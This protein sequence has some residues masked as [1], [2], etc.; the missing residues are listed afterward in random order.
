[1]AVEPVRKRRFSVN[2]LLDGFFFVFAGVASVW[3]AWLVLTESFAFGWWGIALFVVFWLA[4]RLPR[5]PTAA[6][7]P[8]DDLRARLLH[9][10]CAHERRAARRS[11]EPCARRRRGIRAR[12]DARRRMDARRRR[13][14][15]FELAHRDLDD[16]QTQL[17]RGA[18]QP[19][20]PLRTRAGLRLSAGGRGKPGETPPRALL[21]HARGMAPAR[22]PPC[23]LA[24]RRHLRP[25]GRVLAV[26]AAGHAQDRRR[27]RCR[28]RPHRRDRARRQPSGTRRRARRLLDR[29]PLPQ[30]RRRHHPHR[31]RPAGARPAVR[32]R[33]ERVEAAT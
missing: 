30:R 18:G 25:R 23:G 32:C 15:R 28:A 12:R 31:R 24:R 5:A 6:S 27:H 9:R 13:D 1:M 16:H 29:V 26:H 3:L 2:A 10:S 21:A 19:A 11:R 8:D 20:L 14:G 22:R 17:R 4:A 7:H 33:S